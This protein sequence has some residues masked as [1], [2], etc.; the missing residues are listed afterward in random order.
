MNTELKDLL[1]IRCEDEI[2]I[3][4][5]G[6]HPLITDRTDEYFDFLDQPEFESFDDWLHS[7][8]DSV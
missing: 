8:E 3:F 1:E 2:D 5:A 7:M 4:P 6:K